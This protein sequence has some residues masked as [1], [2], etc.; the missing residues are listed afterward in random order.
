MGIGESFGIAF[1]KAQLAAGTGLPQS[2]RVF[3]SLSD[4]DKAAGLDVARSLIELGFELV[5]TTG[6]ASFLEE[7]EIAVSRVVKKYGASEP[8]DSAVELIADGFVQLVINTPSGSN[9]YADGAAIRRTSTV[10]AVPCLTTV[11]AAQAA[12]LGIGET[13]KHGW[14]V[15]SLQEL[16]R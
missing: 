15:T 10:H 1:A 12:V 9:A 2:G 7:H 16:H 11:A 8:G 5:A 13:K 6:T 4:R 14:R 3:L